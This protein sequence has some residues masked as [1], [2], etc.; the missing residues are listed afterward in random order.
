M[1]CKR[2]IGQ[3]APL[4]RREGEESWSLTQEQ[5][6]RVARILQVVSEGTFEINLKAQALKVAKDLET[7]KPSAGWEV[8]PYVEVCY[9]DEESIDLISTALKLLP[10]FG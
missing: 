2:S 7:Y 6:L 10:K 5:C 1:V 8:S 4:F 9:M 3:E